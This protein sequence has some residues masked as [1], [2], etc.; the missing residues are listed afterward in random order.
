M[1][2]LGLDP[3]LATLGYGLVRGDGQELEAVAYGVV[4][5]PAGMAIAERLVLL[6]DA[7]AEIIARYRPDESAVEELFFGTNART[8]IMVGEARGVVLLTLAQAGLPIAE[9]TPMQVKQAT[10]GYGQAVKQQVQEMVRILL[11]LDA[12]PRPDD[13]A[14]ALAVSICHHHSARLMALVGS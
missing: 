13:A 4:R 14:D 11:C 5:T 7:L 10:T 6:H 1:L 3:G 12:I 9:Y 8:A 2:V